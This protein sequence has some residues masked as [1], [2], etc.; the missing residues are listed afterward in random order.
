MAVLFKTLAAHDI[1]LVQALHTKKARQLEHQFLIEGDKTVRE[2]LAS[3]LE[4]VAVY[5]VK[6]WLHE[7]K[8]LIPSTVTI[9]SVT[10]SELKKI[11]THETPNG[12]LAVAHIPTADASLTIENE[13]C[14]AGD[15]LNDPGNLG[16]IIRI[17]DWFGIKKIFLSPDSVDAYNPKT[18]SAAKGSLFRTRIVYAPLPKVIAANPTIDIYGAFMDGENIY[19]ASLGNSGLIVI[20]NEANGIR[21]DVQK[22]ITKKIAIPS[23]GSAESLNAAIAT[24]IIVSEF[25]RQSN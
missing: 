9:Y 20:G 8:D 23:F 12:V 19:K 3:D 25:K 18:V 17:A 10:E 21:E 24:G 22:L 7:H 4:V 11:A 5:A 16:A 14:I 15:N 2:L 13:L 6:S 1:A